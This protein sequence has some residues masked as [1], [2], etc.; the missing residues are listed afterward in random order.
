M[1]IALGMLASDGIVLAADTEVSWGEHLKTEGTKITHLESEGL[2][3][4]GAGDGDYLDAITYELQRAVR[5]LSTDDIARIGRELRSVLERFHRRHVLP[6]KD[7]ALDFVLLIGVQKKG[8]RALWV[9]RKATMRPCVYA[10]I[11]VGS[12]D[13]DSILTQLFENVR[14][15]LVTVTMAQFIATYAIYLV[16]DRVIGCGKNTDMVVIRDGMARQLS[17]ADTGRLEYF[18]SRFQD[19]QTRVAQF[20]SGYIVTN[21]PK[22]EAAALADFFLSLRSEYVQT[23]DFRGVSRNWTL[24]GFPLPRVDISELDDDEAPPTSPRR[25][26]SRPRTLR[27]SPKRNARQ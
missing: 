14:T 13:A 7:P 4:A 19:L 17:R 10:T 24:G 26:K 6:W 25:Q 21:N 12:A 20:A 3:I 18:V 9:T 2:A 8:R 5:A 1:T 15:P 16:K 22:S 23:A 11:G 27:T